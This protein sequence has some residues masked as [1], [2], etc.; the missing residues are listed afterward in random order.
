MTT[1]IFS[2]EEMDDIMEIVKSFEDSVL[3]IESVS[4][5][6]KNEAKEKM[7]IS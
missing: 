4:E 6:N 2:N 7:W 5:E 1:L 3:F